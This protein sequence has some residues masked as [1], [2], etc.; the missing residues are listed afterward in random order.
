MHGRH[1]AA[2]E[3][4]DSLDDFLSERKDDPY[5]DKIIGWD[6]SDPRVLVIS[7]KNTSLLL[8]LLFRDRKGLLK[9]C[10]QTWSPTLTGLL[11]VIWGCVYI[12]S[13]PECWVSFIDIARRCYLF[14]K[15]DISGV[16]QVFQEDAHRHLEL[17][18]S[19]RTPTAMDLED[20]R[21]QLSMLI[22]RIRSEPGTGTND[23]PFILSFYFLVT[24]S[25]PQVDEHFIPGVEDLF[26]PLLRES[27]RSFWRYFKFESGFASVILRPELVKDRIGILTIMINL[28]LTHLFRHPTKVITMKQVLQAVADLGVVEILAKAVFFTNDYSGTN[29][30]DK[31]TEHFGTFKMF[32]N[33]VRYISQDGLGAVFRHTST[34][35]FKVY[36]FKEMQDV[37]FGTS[38][39]HEEWFNITINFWYELG[40]SLDYILPT[41]DY[42]QNIPLCSYTRC[43]DP[44]AT[45]MGALECGLG[46]I[47]AN[48]SSTQLFMVGG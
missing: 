34:D 5:P 45:D 31:I 7:K 47:F 4:S 30:I 48:I 2:E 33:N 15:A 6:S 10:S 39:R 13:T 3:L 24:F 21:L 26:I 16:I 28:M 37:F 38:T 19:R 17:W 42:M 22:E 12:T 9:T 25:L 44:V 11:F 32:A 14:T 29:D 43:P 41:A 36:I 20:A 40:A 8:D 46:N 1:D 35:W 18:L 23:V 27:F